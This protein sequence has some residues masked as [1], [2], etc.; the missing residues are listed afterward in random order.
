MDIEVQRGCHTVRLTTRTESATCK[1]GLI[2]RMLATFACSVMGML[3]SSFV[4][5]GVLYRLY[6]Q[7]SKGEAL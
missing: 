5:C 1:K 7:C 2:H 4:A 3:Y 6:I